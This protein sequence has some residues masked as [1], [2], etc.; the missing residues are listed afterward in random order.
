MKHYF[1]L[2]RSC[3]KNVDLATN[4]HKLQLIVE[5]FSNLCMPNMTQSVTLNNSLSLFNEIDEKAAWPELFYVERTAFWNNFIMI[6]YVDI[7]RLKLWFHCE[8][9]ISEAANRDEHTLHIE[10]SW[11]LMTQIWTVLSFYV[12]LSDWNTTP[13]PA[14]ISGFISLKFATFQETKF[15]IQSFHLKRDI[16]LSS[17]ATPLSAYLSWSWSSRTHLTIKS[18]QCT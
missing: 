13:C 10:F 14:F 17:V 9:I 2:W 15:P 5:H 12:S 6:Y 11:I 16:F 3:H 7:K 1:E 8:Y 4:N 18:S